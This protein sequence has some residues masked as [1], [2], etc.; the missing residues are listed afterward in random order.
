[1]KITQKEINRADKDGFVVISRPWHDEGEYKYQVSLV[2]V[3]TQLVVD[4]MLV[5]KKMD[6][7]RECAD[8]LRWK[9]KTG[10]ST[11]YTD[12]ARHRP[13]EKRQ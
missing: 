4:S 11:N 8:L 13:S 10:G 3:N 12:K 2:N 9:D 6:L 1:M 7:S 5:E